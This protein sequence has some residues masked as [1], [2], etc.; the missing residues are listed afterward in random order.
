[1]LGIYVKTGCAVYTANWG[2]VDASEVWEKLKRKRRRR[3]K[4]K[5]RKLTSF[6]FI[7]KFY[8]LAGGFRIILR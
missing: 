3:R 5:R 1:M 2:K 4:K 6:I 7:Y 8:Q